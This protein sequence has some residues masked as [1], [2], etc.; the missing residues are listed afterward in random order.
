MGRLCKINISS[1][2]VSNP[3]PQNYEVHVL[4]TPVT[5]PLMGN[6]SDDIYKLTVT[7]HTRGGQSGSSKIELSGKSSQVQPF[8]ERE[9]HV[10][11]LP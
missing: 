8:F 6:M 5:M 4:T 11:Q 9:I 7:F 1:S 10:T 3:Q 2:L